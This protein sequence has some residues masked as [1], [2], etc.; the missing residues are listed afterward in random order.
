MHIHHRASW[1]LTVAAIVATALFATGC[2]QSSDE[3]LADPG[4]SPTA[5]PLADAPPTFGFV[6]AVDPVDGR[7]ALDPAEWLTGDEAVEAARAA[8][9]LGPGE[10]DVPNDY[11]IRNTTDDEVWLPLASDATLFVM[12]NPGDPT[13]ETQVTLDQLAAWVDSN[14]LSPFTVETTSSGDVTELRFVYRP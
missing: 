9:D 8:G 2:A 6:T 12:T 3:P 7:V 13:T 1:R 4:V 5:A 11:Y 14:A 10:T